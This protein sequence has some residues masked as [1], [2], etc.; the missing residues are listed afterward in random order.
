MR[1]ARMARQLLGMASQ[2]KQAL[3]DEEY[4]REL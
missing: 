4:G 3:F 2:R 1:D